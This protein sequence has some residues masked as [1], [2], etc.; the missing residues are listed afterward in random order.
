MTDQASGVGSASVLELFSQVT[1]VRARSAGTFEAEASDQWTIVGRPNGGYLLAL[2]GRAASAMTDS[3]HV[4][5]ASAH[6]L[7][8]PDPGPVE[9][10][11]ELLRRGRSISQ[12]RVRMSQGGRPCVEALMSTSDLDPSAPPPRWDVGAPEVPPVPFDECLRLEAVTPDGFQAPIMDQVDLRLEPELKNG[13]SSRNPSGLGRLRGWL[14][15]PGG[16]SF[17]PISLLYAVD[18]FPPATFDTELSCLASTIEL[19]AYVRAIPA[20]GP[21]RVANRARLVDTQCVD[22]T[23]DVWDGDGRLVAHATQ[24]AK[25]LFL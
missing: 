19:T 14:E 4:I 25:V 12:V 23:C 6:Y 20:P 18:A 17:D 16:E 8:S 13:L 2:L 7:R 3:G 10:E 21:V 5:A 24:L 9:I 11:G 15:L 1:S 22:Q